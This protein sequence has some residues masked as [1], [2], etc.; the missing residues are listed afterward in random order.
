MK[1]ADE[2]GD[3]KLDYK[4]FKTIIK[5]ANN[6]GSKSFLFRSEASL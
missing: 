2:D 6:S 1:N 3:G 4:E 5:V